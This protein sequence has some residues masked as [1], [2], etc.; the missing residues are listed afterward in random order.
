MKDHLIFDTTDA[1]TIADSDN[2]GAFLRSDV[3]TLLTHTSVTKPANDMITV[4]FADGDVTVGTDTINISAHGLETGDKAQLTTTGTLPAGLALATDYFVI[5]VDADNIKLA[6]SVANAEAGTAVDI[7][8]AAGGGTHTAT[9]APDTDK[10]LDVHVTKSVLQQAEDTPHISGDLGTMA[11]AV[12]NDSEGTLADA[13]GDYT[14]LQVDSL[15]R[16]RVIADLDITNLAD[17]AEDSVHSSGDIGAYVLSVRADTR[18]TDANTSADGDYAS[19]F[20][21]NSGELY[22]HDTDVLAQLVTM[23]AVLDNILTDTNSLVVDIDVIAAAFKAED[24]AHVSGDTGVQTLLVRQDTLA[25]STDADGDYGS[26]KS[27]NLGELYVT[28]TDAIALLTTIDGDTSNIAI[29]TAVIAGDTTSID[30]TLTALTRAE[31]SVHVSGDQGIMGLAVRNDTLGSLVDADGDYAPLQVNASGELYVTLNGSEILTNDTANTAITATATA[32]DNTVGG[33][34]LKATDL[35]DRKYLFLYNNGNRK[36]FVGPS[37]L[38]TAT[39]FPVS[40]GSYLELR[41]GAA[42]DL[43]AIAPTGSAQDFRIM[44]MS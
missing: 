40:P 20:V 37:G 31:D 27:N 42:I 13:D 12:R 41:A 32:V 17:K 28:D 5:R 15:G 11:L 33:T 4:T 26:F 35:A 3:G 8:A 43:Y 18:P 30:A 2:V 19:L 23:D 24:S 44:E 29:D 1:A 9:Q 14:P 7:T 25:A 39:G 21:N 16:L 10:S 36:C 34:D 38:T 22:V 6:S